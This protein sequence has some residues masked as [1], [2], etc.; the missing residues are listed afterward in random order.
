MVLKRQWSPGAAYKRVMGLTTV[1][2]AADH[3]AEGAVSE[4]APAAW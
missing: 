3:Q 2:R 4:E 1:L